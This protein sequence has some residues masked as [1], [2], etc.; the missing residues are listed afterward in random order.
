MKH[1]LAEEVTIVV[2][3]VRRVTI[4]TVKST[5]SWTVRVVP[6]SALPTRS[7]DDHSASMMQDPEIE[8]SHRIHVRETPVKKVMVFQD[9]LASVRRR[10]AKVAAARGSRGGLR[11]NES[12]GQQ[13]NDE[14]GDG[15]SGGGPHPS[16]ID[17]MFFELANAESVGYR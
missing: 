6:V 7:N 10:Q 13:H 11:H 12:R 3:C 9:E 4:E 1:G 17:E 5:C 14:A 16:T 2:A 8:Q 15:R